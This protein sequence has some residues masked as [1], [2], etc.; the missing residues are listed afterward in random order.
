MAATSARVSAGSAGWSVPANSA[1]GPAPGVVEVGGCFR[2]PG[3][4]RAKSAED[5]WAWPSTCTSTSMGSSAGT[6]AG[7]RAESAAFSETY[8]SPGAGNFALS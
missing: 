3:S 2:G 1:D 4:E 7:A 5:A 6:F 8:H